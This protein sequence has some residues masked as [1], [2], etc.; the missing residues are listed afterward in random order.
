M[1]FRARGVVRGEAGVSGL[2]SG[3][4]GCVVVAQLVGCGAPG[5]ASDDDPNVRADGGAT[6]GATTTPAA[7]ASASATAATSATPASS[8]SASPS[9]TATATGTASPPDSDAPDAS[10]AG[11][12]SLTTGSSDAGAS[13]GSDDPTLGDDAALPPIVD[14]GLPIVLPPALAPPKAIFASATLDLARADCGGAAVTAAFEVTNGGAQT[15]TVAVRPPARRA[16]GPSPSRRPGSTSRPGASVHAHR[17][18][19]GHRPGDRRHPA[20]GSLVLTTNDPDQPHASIPLSVTPFGAT[21]AWAGGAAA[22]FGLAHLAQLD[23]PIGLSLVNSGNVPASVF[24]GSPSDPQFSLSPPG[25]QAVPAG[26]TL[27]LV[28][29]FLPALLGAVSATL[30]SPSAARCAARSPRRLTLSGSGGAGAISGWPTGLLDFGANPCGGL[31][32]LTQGFT[33]TNTGAF[34]VHLTSASFSGGLGYAHDVTP[35]TTIPAGGLAHRPRHPAVH[36]VPLA[37]PRAL[38]RHALHRHRRGG[39][40]GAPGLG[41]PGGSRRGPRAR[42]QRER[43]VRRLRRHPA[44]RLDLAG[45]QRAQHRQRA[46]ERHAQLRRTSSGWRR[47]ASSSRRA[48]PSRTRSPSCRR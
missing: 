43:V 35:G 37:G 21:L 8:A 48:A 19:L 32:A 36:P 17:Q 29:D 7:S 1:R 26:G 24:L 39:R 42:H 27:S 40:S 20:R 44:P 4:L 11:D 46:V 28:A 45:L 13:H 9:P 31:A 5:G 38:R 18:R 12:A 2:V 22:N 14:A 41:H 3:V 6:I 15:L 34:D 23:T 47:R 30:P 16:P 33:L 25:A 10:V